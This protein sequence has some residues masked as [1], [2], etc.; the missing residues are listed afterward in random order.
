MSLLQLPNSLVMADL[1]RIQAV[2]ELR[3]LLF[4]SLQAAL[5]SIRISTGF[6]YL[7]LS[8]LNVALQL[9]SLLGLFG[10]ISIGGLQA[11]SQLCQLA[12]HR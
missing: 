8:L 6:R 5:R 2:C 4:R 7:V 10:Q 12:F 1:G 11:G 3:D 9:R